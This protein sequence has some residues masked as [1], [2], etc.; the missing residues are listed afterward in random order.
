MRMYEMSSFRPP[1]MPNLSDDAI[2]EHKF[3]FCQEV[4]SPKAKEIDL[5]K[6]PCFLKAGFLD[7]FFLFW[8]RVQKIL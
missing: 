7:L 4:A 1:N 3:Y 6:E 5:R 8:F 2:L